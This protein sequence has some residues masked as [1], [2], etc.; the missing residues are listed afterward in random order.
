[1]NRKEF[2]HPNYEAEAERKLRQALIEQAE[3]KAQMEEV[4]RKKAEAEEL[5]RQEREL[6][7]EWLDGDYDE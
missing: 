7:E 6:D 4:A 1:M 5:L 2:T 3:M